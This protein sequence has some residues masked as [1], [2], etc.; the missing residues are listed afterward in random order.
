[1]LLVVVVVVCVCLVC[2]VA[3]LSRYFSLAL[4]VYFVIHTVGAFY[5]LSQQLA[6]HVT[7][8]TNILLPQNTNETKK[9]ENPKKFL[10]RYEDMDMGMRVATYTH[11]IAYIECNTGMFWK[12]GLKTEQDFRSW[13]EKGRRN[14]RLGKGRSKPQSTTSITSSGTTDDVYWTGWGAWKEGGGGL[15]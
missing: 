8:T 1:V 10:A 7:Q 3:L 2:G 9:K 6:R 13:W 4:S 12:H 15:G 5:F 11:P 14:K